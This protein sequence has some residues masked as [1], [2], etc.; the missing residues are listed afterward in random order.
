MR[1]NFKLGE[2]FSG[3]GGIGY[4]A[5]TAKISN[6]NFSISHAWA[7]DYDKDTCHTYEANVAL[8]PGTVV[9]G[10]IRKLNFQ[11]LHEIS[12]I[13]ALAFGF[14]CNDFSVVGEQK[15]MDGVYGPLYS[16]GIKALKE[17]K[18]KWF[19]AENVGG[20]RNSNDGKSFSKILNEMYNAGYTVYPHLYKFE[21]YGVPQ[22]RHRI[23]IIGIREDIDVIYKV[24]SVKPFSFNGKTC[25][26]AEGIISENGNIAI[27][28][29]P[30]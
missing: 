16:F 15:G 22:A 8:K 1:M 17:F 4:A 28:V 10:D 6:P 12:E 29:S 3:P 23:I 13:D 30:F 21:K 5:I 20:L 27:K 25:K 26:E 18:P 24:P 2:L 11:K 9:C 19:L 14:P 7:N